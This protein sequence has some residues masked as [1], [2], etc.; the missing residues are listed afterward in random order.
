M[1]SVP[2]VLRI[3]FPE[4]STLGDLSWYSIDACS[5][6]PRHALNIFKE[7]GFVIVKG[8]MSGEAAS[9]V[10][11]TCK[12]LAEEMRRR[13]TQ[14][15]G[16]RNPGRYT[17]GQLKCLRLRSF[18][19]HFLN[20][21]KVFDVLE[22]IY[23]GS[24]SDPRFFVR[25]AGGD[26]CCGHT[27]EFQK[28]HSDMRPAC[29]LAPHL[30]D[31]SKGPIHARET[32]P[33]ISVNFCTD[34]LH[35]WNGPMR[36]VGYPEMMKFVGNNPKM[37]APKL[38]E[39]LEKVPDWLAMKIFPLEPGDALIRDIR[40]WHG[41]CPNLSGVDRFL[42]GLEV[43]SYGRMKWDFENQEAKGKGK[44]WYEKTYSLPEKFFSCLN[45][46]VQSYC[47]YVYDPKLQPVRHAAELFKRDISAPP[48]D[49]YQLACVSCLRDQ[50][51]KELISLV[52]QLDCMSR[53]P[54][55]AFHEFERMWLESSIALTPPFEEIVEMLRK[56]C[57]E[58]SSPKEEQRQAL[59]E[60][61][62][63]KLMGKVV[64][65]SRE[66]VTRSE[67]SM[68][69]QRGTQWEDAWWPR[70]AK[71]SAAQEYDTNGHRDADAP[72]KRRR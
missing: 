21:S 13:D 43:E 60:F 51:W 66:D 41:G 31:Q 56:S 10:H 12:E 40:V 20:C 8:A 58:G 42:P 36:I 69:A 57:M 63:D 11:E 2:E 25:K 48:R 39:E 46:R 29:P 62:L 18:A 28:I 9:E 26:Y 6:D 65:C 54:R 34:A 30:G 23:G 24:G 19:T 64:L 50:R 33:L 47:R 67:Q 38:E 49:A 68:E 71:R 27:S 15:I 55:A 72:S 4:K 44:G 32:P 53:H 1:A 16:N 52:A 7:Y 22:A 17:L 35:R 45:P 5:G 37:D 3:A 61:F 14:G 59:K 70:H